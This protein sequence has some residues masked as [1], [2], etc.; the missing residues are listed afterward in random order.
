MIEKKKFYEIK[1][2][3]FCR[4][5]FIVGKYYILFYVFNSVRFDTHTPHTCGYI[6]MYN[7]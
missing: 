2:N 5:F 7:V 1:Q 6:C 4:D 3:N